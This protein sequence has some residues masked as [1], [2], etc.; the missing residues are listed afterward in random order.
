MMDE[1]TLISSPIL[2]VTGLVQGVT[3]QEL[4]QVL[5]ECL[6]LRL[7]LNRDNSLPA[8][9]PL[10]GTI[11]FESISKAEQA[12]ATCNQQTFSSHHCVLLLSSSPSPST[13]N[14]IPSAQ[15]RLLKSLPLHYT[16]S[17]IYQLC[18]PF[19]PI[20][21]CTLQLSPSFPPG[22]PPEFKGLALVRFYKEGDAKEMEEGLNFVEVERGASLVVQKWDDRRGEKARVRAERGI[23]RSSD[24]SVDSFNGNGRSIL[25]KEERTSQ[26]ANSRYSTTTSTSLGLNAGAP[27]F[28][29][30]SNMSRNVSGNSM[31][32]NG[33]GETSFEEEKE[34]QVTKGSQAASSSRR[35]SLA[36]TSS[37][38]V[39]QREGEGI[40][41]CNLFIKSLPSTYTS[42]SLSTLFSPYGSI[43]SALV[44]T[45]PQTQRSKEFG[46]VSFRT[47]EEARN[48]L[49]GIDGRLVEGRK[50]TVRLH[51]PK[52]VREGRL[53]GGI[54]G[55]TEGIKELKTSTIASPSVSSSPDRTTHVKSE[56]SCTSPSL[57]EHDRLVSAV[58]AIDAKRANEIVELIEGLPRKERVMCL[59]NPE[60]LRQKVQDA[61]L[62]LEAMDEEPETRAVS[63][64]SLVS[65]SQPFSPTSIPSSIPLLARLPASQIVPL[66]P[67]VTSTLSL[68][69]PSP[70]DLAQTKEFMNSLL[71][72][73]PSQIKQKLGEKLFKVIKSTGVKR[74]PKITID[75]LDTEELDSL[76][77]LVHYPE[78]LK[79]KALLLTNNNQAK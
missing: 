55:L 76:S 17:R 16:S 4:L 47:S 50:V 79:E 18:R 66:L 36:A 22:G 24:V 64:A 14:P 25:E 19:G 40:D 63:T 67:L 43:V 15:A 74:A 28:V 27:E 10:N 32:S 1:S 31:W 68:S 69:K 42:S 56:A 62:V 59:F 11:E 7:N 35:G 9:A 51:E 44:V 20:H 65:T 3:D 54:E 23:G 33:T 6:K 38:K 21:S 41:P 2:Y 60:V 34:D 61:L 26:W 78:I 52:R 75:L 71:G 48:A 58:Q 8:Q 29:T 12:F 73:S 53:S 49:E 30:S 46:F 39:Q 57:S 77:V 37:R 70:A 5:S 72:S 13:P 45:D